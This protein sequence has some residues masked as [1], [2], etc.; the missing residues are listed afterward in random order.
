MDI[1]KGHPSGVDVRAFMQEVEPRIYD[2][3]EEDLGS[4]LNQV[5]ACTHGPA[6]EGQPRR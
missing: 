1:S 6:S 2:K 3:L 5:S 4:K